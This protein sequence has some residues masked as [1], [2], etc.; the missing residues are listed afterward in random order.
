MRRNALRIMGDLLVTELTCTKTTGPGKRIRQLPVA[1]ALDAQLIPSNW[2]S[3]F[4]ELLQEHLPKDRDYLLDLPTKDFKGTTELRL[5]H[6]QATAISKQIISELRVPVL[7]EQG[8][9][10]GE[11]RAVP[12]ELVDLFSQHSGRAVL[13]SMSIHIES[14]KSKRDCLGRWKP[15]ASDDYMRTYR[16]V[17][18]AIQVKTA[19]AVQAGHV[20]VVKE[21]DIIDRAA[22]HL[23]E[24]KHL[25]EIEVSLICRKW[26]ETISG[27]ASY[28]KDKWVV[29]C[30]AESAPISLL[31]LASLAKIKPLHDNSSNTGKAREKVCRQERFLITYSRN[32]KISRLHST[33]RGCYWAGVEVRDFWLGNEVDESMYNRRCKFCWPELL[34]KEECGSSSDEEDED[35]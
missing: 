26:H 7:T 5:N 32:R 16:N 29:N 3:L 10:A 33:E 12:V 4:L 28:L 15:S 8:W 21:H 17:V 27:F 11:S 6:S 1:V 31:A 24:R 13:P 22:R 14:D 20:D 18:A 35:E 19:K 34:K 23:R 9:E 30:A 2:L 25:P